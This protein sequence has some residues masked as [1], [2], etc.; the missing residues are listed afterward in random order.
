MRLDARGR[1]AFAMT[2]CSGW[3]LREIR[4]CSRERR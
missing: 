4:S 3:S 2:I 1:T